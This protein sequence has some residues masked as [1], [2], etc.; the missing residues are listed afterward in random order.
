MPTKGGITAVRPTTRD[1][2][3]ST[4]NKIR[5]AIFHCNE[6]CPTCPSSVFPTIRKLLWNQE[7]THDTPSLTTN[8][9]AH[10]TFT[11]L[12][13]YGAKHFLRITFVCILHLGAQYSAVIMRDSSWLT[14][15][16][17]ILE[18]AENN[19]PRQMSSSLLKHSRHTCE[20]LSNWDNSVVNKG[21]KV[22]PVEDLIL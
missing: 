6:K 17:C 20:H 5:K 7:V 11:H 22:S 21:E 3:V 1:R 19:N 4:F 15:T 2:E 16:D 18:K 13:A 12:H 10:S 8:P 9:N 14:E